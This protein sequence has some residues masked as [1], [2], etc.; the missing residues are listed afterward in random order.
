MGSS[1]EPPRFD[2]DAGTVIGWRDGDLVRAT[3]I[4]YARAERFQVPEPQPPA[5]VVAA[6]S[7]APACPQTSPPRRRW[8]N[9]GLHPDQDGSFIGIRT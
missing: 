7:R 4:G 9:R 2:C 1:Q 5:E 3:G 8:L 6:T